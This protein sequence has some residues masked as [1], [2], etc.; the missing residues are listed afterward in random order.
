MMAIAIFGLRPPA[1][2]GSTADVA[3]F[4]GF[5]LFALVGAGEQESPKTLA[6]EE[7]RLD[8][9]TDQLP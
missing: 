1:S 2:H 3:F 9:I 8:P 7:E 6:N 4:G 5:T